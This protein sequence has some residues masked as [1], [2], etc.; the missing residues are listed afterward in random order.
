MSQYCVFIDFSLHLL[1]HSFKHHDKIFCHFPYSL[2]QKNYQMSRYS[3]SL[4]SLVLLRYS[5]P[6][7]YRI[8]VLL[9]KL[10]S[11]KVATIIKCCDNT[12]AF[13][14]LLCCDIHFC[15]ATFF[16][17]FFSCCVATIFRLSCCT[18]LCLC[19][20]TVLLVATNFCKLSW[21]FVTTL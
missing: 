14:F 2:L 3:S 16:L 20:D 21:G 7:H 15:I 11:C 1:R 19:C 4:P 8:L 6:C 12:S 13:R 5:F 10:F 17:Y 9:Q 18:L